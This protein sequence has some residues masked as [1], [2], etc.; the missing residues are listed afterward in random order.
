MF[1]IVHNMFL[2]IYLKHLR[3]FTSPWDPMNSINPIQGWQP[4][5]A[6]KRPERRTPKPSHGTGA[7]EYTGGAWDRSTGEVSP[8]GWGSH[9]W[10]WPGWWQFCDGDLFGMVNP[11]QRWND[12]Q[13]RG[14]KGH[15]ESPGDGFSQVEDDSLWLF[16]D[17]FLQM[18]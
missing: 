15:F 2:Y 14:Y 18:G 7:A 1:C 6:P 13:I 5:P 16:D 12:L 10:W 11:L 4:L 17:V 9:R 3:Y 8:A